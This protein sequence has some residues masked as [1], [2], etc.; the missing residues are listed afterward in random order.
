MSRPMNYESVASEFDRRYTNDD[1]NGL[2][3]TLCK[4]LTGK[5]AELLLEIGCGTGH[6]LEVT[7]KLGYRVVGLDPSVTMLNLARKK[8][9][10]KLLVQGR[11]EAIPFPPGIF[12]RVFLINVLHHARDKERSVA[13][14]FRVLKPGGKFM[15]IGLDPHTGFDRWSIY[16]YWPETLQIDKERYLPT[17]EIRQILRKQG[18][19]K[20]RTSV[21]Q[22]MIQRF[23]AN[24]AFKSGRLAENVTSQLGVLTADEYNNGIHRLL[25]D[26][27]D[28]ESKGEVLKTYS[29][30]RLYA[31][32][33]LKA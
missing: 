24:E 10:Q 18:F 32:V 19:I 31:T 26:I 25:K 30:L 1:Y 29:N 21:A 13:E 22:S 17:A 12:D 33:G 6:W 2:E 14:A 7:G 28:S 3:Q 15:T 23:P 8:V 27:A 9:S 4:F 11:A 16:D 20:C 5:P